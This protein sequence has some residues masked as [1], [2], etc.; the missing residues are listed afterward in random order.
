[1]C[2]CTV[3]IYTLFPC[4][5]SNHIIIVMSIAGSNINVQI[6]VKI[7]AKMVDS[8]MGEQIYKIS[9]EHFVASESNKSTTNRKTND[10]Q[11][12]NHTH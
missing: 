2:L 11:T 9:L 8:K 7:C 5:V 6:E 1:M 10:K 3:K 4:S 12:K